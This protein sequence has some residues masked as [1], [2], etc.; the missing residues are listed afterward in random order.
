[1]GEFRYFFSNSV[2]ARVLDQVTV[3]NACIETCSIQVQV[4]SYNYGPHFGN[5]QEF[6]NALRDASWD[7]EPE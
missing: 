5:V 6:C 2:E 3:C 4:R 1:M 7:A